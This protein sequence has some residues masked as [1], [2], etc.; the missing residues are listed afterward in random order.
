MYTKARVLKQSARV[1]EH[2]PAA[3]FIDVK[4]NRLLAN[5]TSG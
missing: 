5:R 2:M 3:C 1:R 4:A